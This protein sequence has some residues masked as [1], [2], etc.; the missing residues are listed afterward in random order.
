MSQKIKEA[1]NKAIELRN[2]ATN[3]QKLLCEDFRNYS[4]EDSEVY[5]N[6]ER[7]KED[8]DNVFLMLN[9]WEVRK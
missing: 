8:L 9:R 5:A 2:E 3:L 7:I 4:D 1:K 6:L